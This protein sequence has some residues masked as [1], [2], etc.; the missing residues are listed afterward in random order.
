MMKGTNHGLALILLIGAL[1]VT[2]SAAFAIDAS[3]IARL[4]QKA[5]RGEQFTT[6]E[7]QLAAEAT[8]Q[9]G[10]RIQWPAQNDEPRLPR[11]PL[12][13]YIAAEVDYEW[14]D[15]TDIGTEAGI[16]GDDQSVG[17]F[18]L[19]F[20]F[21]YYDESYS[22][23]YMTSNGWATFQ[24]QAGWSQYWNVE[25]PDFVDPH[26]AF[27]IFWD[28]LY[29]PAGGQYYYWADPA[30]QRFVMSWIDV[31][32]IS[33][34]D[35]LHTFQIILYPNGNIRY[36][37]QTVDQGVIGNTS[38][39]VGIENS[40]SSEGLQVCNEGVGL[41]P[42]SNMSLLIGQ[43]DGVPAPVTNLAAVVND[44]DVTLTWTDPT[45]DTNGNPLTV[46]NLQ[47]WNGRP[48]QGT[49]VATVAPGVQTYTIE[50]MLDG[51][52][53]IY[54]RAFNNPYYGGADRVNIIIG[55]PS[56]QNTFDVNNGQWT[57]DNGWVWGAPTNPA[58][59]GAFSDPNAWGTDSP[60]GYPG[61]ADYQ[62]SLSP[63]LV[64]QSPDALMEFYLYYDCEDFWD[65]ANLKVSIDGGLTW[66]VAEPD[67]GYPVILFDFTPT[68]MAGQ[69][70][71][72][73]ISGGWE[74][75]SI[76]LAPF[77][78]E[79][80]MFRFDFAADDFVS[81][82]P[83][84]YFDDMVIWGLDEPV[85]TTMAGTVTLN[86]GNAP[87]T[88][89]QLS[90]NGYTRPTGSPQADGTFL[91][92]SVLAGPRVLDAV[93]AGYHPV[94]TQVNVPEGGATGVN[95]TLTRLDPP[96]PANLTGSIAS[97]TGVVTLNWDDSSDPLVDF[98]TVYR[99][100]D[101]INE[102][103]QVG[104][105]VASTF[106]ETLTEDGIYF[107]QVTATDEDV[108]TP[109][110]SEPSDQIYL[111]YG[112][113][114]V[115]QIGLNGNF[116]DRIRVSWSPPGPNVGTELFYDDGTAEA[117]YV[118]SF[119]A[120]P[121]DYF[122]VRMTPPDDASF[123]LMVYGVSVFV[124][125][126][127]NIPWIGVCPPLPNGEGA[128]VAN[129]YYEWTDLNAESSPGWV[130]AETNFD[131]FLTEPGDFYI[132]YQ[133]PEGQDDQPA[134][135]SDDT[136]V[137][138]RSYWT[139]TP[140][141]FWNPW[142][143]HDWMM[144]AWLGGPPPDTALTAR[145]EY[146]LLQTGTP[147]G[148]AV[149]RV[150]TLPTTGRTHDLHIATETPV[151]KVVARGPLA[152]RNAVA[153]PLDRWFA[154]YVTAPTVELASRDNGRSLDDIVNYK[155]Y[156]GGT[157]I[158]QPVETFYF[159]LNRVENT[160]YSYYVT[161]MYDNGI[162]SAPSPTRTGVCNMP[163]GAPLNLI[164]TPV[165]TSQMALA[166]SAPTTNRDGTP[167]VDLAQ[168]KVYRNETLIATLA[169]GTTTYVD[170]PPENDR[171]YTW[172][173]TAQDEVP[174]VSDPS[175]PYQGAVVSPF[176][177]VDY[178]W[179]DITG[180][181]TQLTFEWWGATSGPHDIGF[182]YPYLDEEYTQVWISPGGWV[183]FMEAFGFYF[184]ESIPN[185]FDP[186]AAIYPFWD[187]LGAG[188]DGGNVY[189]YQDA[190]EDRFIVSWVDIPH[191]WD[192]T[193]RYTFQLIL[194]EGGAAIFNYQTIPSDGWPGNMDCTVGIED[195]TSTEG[196]QVFYQGSGFIAPVSE[197]AIAFW[198]GPSGTITGLVREFGSNTPLANARVTV[199]EVPDLFALSDA[200]GL[201]VLEVEPG[202]YN[203]RIHLQGYCDQ[204]ALNVDVAD[205]DTETR[206]FT[207]RQPNV[208]FSVTSLNVLSIVGENAT[209]EFEITNPNGQC[210]VEFDITANQNWLTFSTTS[211]SIEANQS[212][213]ID[214]TA[215]SSNFP[216]GDYSAVITINHNDMNNPTT[217]PLTISQASA[218]GDNAELP[219]DF[220]LHQNYPN[221]FNATTVLSFD[222]PTESN[223]EITLF[224]VQGQEVARP[225]DRLMAAGRYNL[226]FDAAGL[227]TGMYLVK[228]S[229]RGYTAVQK[230]VLLK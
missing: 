223:V 189:I 17:P 57:T 210:P 28:D 70:A 93:V 190:A 146:Y 30:G 127:L 75:V 92:D 34:N 148:Y 207:M 125:D 3:E 179:V 12:D 139:Q 73:G 153:N 216:P 159:D 193:F 178:E 228:M 142:G 104:Q 227:P 137:D 96:A 32:H 215:A 154:P 140:N 132:A 63:N 11:R 118:V 23:V 6:A 149:E 105:P 40:N 214:V 48:G 59:P 116:D 60:T 197:S 198:A 133:F 225:V 115:T 18:A 186:H 103:T 199:D 183:S 138:F 21:P 97:A 15:I 54:V 194:E 4:K 37:Y 201:Y 66:Q 209:A 196:V 39:G 111:L 170:T 213:V 168:Y 230:M 191:L 117:F 13:E 38:C 43:P 51:S 101:G 99:R 81:E 221:P 192:L 2:T 131:L 53:T 107:Y 195:A 58:V 181:G 14:V 64:V 98:Y 135:G 173:V 16:T 175:V 166:W 95:V 220:A 56:Y 165:G 172:T 206:N 110:V 62:V 217:I 7:R 205:E 182:T 163:P 85:L 71:W 226:T 123:P 129:A 50:D 188:L 222:V 150:E 161:A 152:S 155:V 147:Q 130:F 88:S 202:V 83:G 24:D 156:R 211:G 77:L 5:A 36:N 121:S 87:V 160:P 1:F 120:G 109:V 20:D 106:Q 10:S 180:I 80:V 69:P 136:Q 122:C 208:A 44:H 8:R 61:L 112:E 176:E 102:W 114:P 171:F 143:A 84:V 45:Q 158:A 204:S 157:M 184:S 151:D 108:S 185:G 79:V 27:Y 224:N 33:A 47:V 94:T 68:P 76:P 9:F 82:L 212:I 174:N 42:I 65:G 72:S 177:S 52:R 203:V 200:A 100:L 124:E 229:A 144:R 49:L 145:T 74:Y 126:Q 29:P 187:E 90:I 86:G 119:P 162:E 41:L 46:D 164:G 89:V 167:L 78:G 219:T 67:G 22:Q 19:G 128:D 134:V 25:I 91:I 141:D 35:E 218:A 169:A 55:N 113:L 31:P 26:N